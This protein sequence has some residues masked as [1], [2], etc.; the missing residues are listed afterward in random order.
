M[1]EGRANKALRRM[2]FPGR[3]EID[4]LEGFVGWAEFYESHQE[5]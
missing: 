2:A 4:D 3:L 1:I 5:H